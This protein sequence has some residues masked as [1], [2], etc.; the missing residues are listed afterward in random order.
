M[1]SVFHTDIPARK[2]GVQ[3][4][5][6]FGAMYPLFIAAEGLTRMIARM[7]SG[8]DGAERL[9]QR[10]LFAEARAN[11]SIATSYALMARTMLQSSG[12]KTRTER[13][14]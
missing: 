8:D 10:S 2:D 13:L 11:A 6:F 4:H 3:S 14:S 7:A 5:L 1:S 12:R 9:Q